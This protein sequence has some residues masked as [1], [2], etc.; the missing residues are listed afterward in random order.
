[1]RKP[2]TISLALVFAG[3][4][5]SSSD[6]E[7][8][9]DRI[10]DLQDEVNALKRESSSKSDVE[11]LNAELVERTEQI[12]RSSADV[13]ARVGSVDER[14]E[15]VQGGLEQTN[16][17]IDR[18]AQQIT[19]QQQVIDRLQRMSTPI[20]QPGLSGPALPP[21]E[22]AIISDPSTAGDPVNVYQTA[23]ADFRRGNFDLAIEG[24]EEFLAANPRSDLADNAS[25]WIGEALFSQGKYADAIV[26]FDRVVSRYPNSEKVAAALLKKGLSYL[27]RG[28]RAQAIIQLQYVIHEHGTSEEAARARE[29][30]RD[31]GITTQ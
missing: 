21:E 27:E 6:I 7:R 9:E 31:L 25:Y 26:R 18:L 15:N 4:C 5:V 13:T 20:S 2:L 23:Y 10:S 1:M 29:K 3:A 22:A 11:R 16:Y 8:L 30:L 19:A 17:R 24:F 12:L 28:Q 14:I